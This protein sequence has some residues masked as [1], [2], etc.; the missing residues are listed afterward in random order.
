MS[1]LMIP[2]VMSIAQWCN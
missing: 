2:A 1:T